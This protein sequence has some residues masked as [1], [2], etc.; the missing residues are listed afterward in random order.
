MV[1]GPKVIISGEVRSIEYENHAY[2]VFLVTG[3]STL[4]KIAVNSDMVSIL[5]PYLHQNIRCGIEHMIED[6]YVMRLLLIN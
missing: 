1:M 2:W 3:P 4:I 6:R 5:E